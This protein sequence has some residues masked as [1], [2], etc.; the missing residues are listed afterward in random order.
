[1]AGTIRHPVFAR[2]YACLSR[3][4]EGRGIADNRAMLLEGLAGR[5]LEVGA[6]NGLNFEHYPSSVAEVVAIEPEPYLRK[7]ALERAP[8]AHIPITVIDA[9]AEAIPFPDSSFD[10]IVASLVLCS[11]GDQPAALAELRRVLRPSGS[12]RYY[13]HVVSHQPRRARLQRLLDATVWP[14]IAGGCHL[15]RDTGAAIRAAGFAVQRE[16]RLSVK[17][18][19]L[20]PAIPHLLGVARLPG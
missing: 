10:A 7:L 1:V 13:E 15:A 2:I 19:A 9:V 17:T 16:Q 12:L 6:G 20:E 11:V 14:R 3:G 8:H 4:A 18:S 5:V